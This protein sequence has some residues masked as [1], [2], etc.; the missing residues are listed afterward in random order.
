MLLRLLTAVFSVRVGAGLLVGMP[1]AASTIVVV[2]DLGQVPLR[3]IPRRRRGYHMNPGTD[4]GAAILPRHRCRLHRHCEQ[5]TR[6][7]RSPSQS[8]RR[9]PF[10]CGENAL[11]LDS[12]SVDLPAVQSQRAPRLPRG[13]RAQYALSCAAVRGES[14]QITRGL[15][16]WRKNSIGMIRSRKK[17]AAGLQHRIP[18]RQGMTS[19]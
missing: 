16:K 6:A 10:S 3:G 11:K 13:E 8:H 1:D 4:W 7:V 12:R 14:I 17:V 19:S 2:R 15:S 18:L 9:L 5:Q